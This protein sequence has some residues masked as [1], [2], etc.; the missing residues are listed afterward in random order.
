MRSGSD[1][2]RVL[3]VTDQPLIAFAMQ[4]LMR[5]MDSAID[6]T[7]CSGPN[8]PLADTHGHCDWHR[9]FLTPDLPGAEGMSLARRACT[10]GLAGRCVL[11]ARTPHAE[12]IREARAAGLLGYIL[13]SASVERFEADLREVMAGRRVYTQEHNAPAAIHLTPRQKDVLALLRKGYSSKQI[14][15]FLDISEG[16]VNNHVATLIRVFGVSNRTQALTR[17]I[18]LGYLSWPA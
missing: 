12:W 6:M 9:V 16:T 17:A 11:V 8:V 3:I 18:E 13:C 10:L 14:A 7:T 2:K 5:S 4:K 1:S 15:A